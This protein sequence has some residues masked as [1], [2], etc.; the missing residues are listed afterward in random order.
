MV[1]VVTVVTLFLLTENFY[2][3]VFAYPRKPRTI[4]PVWLGLFV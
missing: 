4:L 3:Q 1:I 2:K